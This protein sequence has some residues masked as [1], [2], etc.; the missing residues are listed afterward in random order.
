M[1]IATIVGLESL[2]L[3]L[4]VER[5][6]YVVTR[7]A[8]VINLD[9]GHTLGLTVRG[10]RQDRHMVFDA[11]VH[12]H[13]RSAT[14]VRRVRIDLCAIPTDPTV[15]LDLE[16]IVTREPRLLHEKEVEPFS[17]LLTLIEYSLQ[18]VPFG[19]CL[20]VFALCNAPDIPGA[21]SHWE[22]R[23]IE[24]AGDDEAGSDDADDAPAEE[25]K[26]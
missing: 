23:D 10:F 20:A 3:L 5:A 2:S 7:R 16:V 17:L 24:T 14:V 18:V 25:H 9:P 4:Q 15:T 19:I 8:S 6:E 11:V 26:D 22:S 1:R 12:Q 13:T 21:Y